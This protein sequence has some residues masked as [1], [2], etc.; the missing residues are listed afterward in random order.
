MADI[1]VM[2]INDGRIAERLFEEDATE[3][4]FQ[5]VVKIVLAKEAAV[6]EQ[7]ERTNQGMVTVKT[8]PVNYSRHEK[9]SRSYGS[10]E[11][12]KM[13]I[14]NQKCE[15]MIGAN[16][17]DAANLEEKEIVTSVDKVFVGATITLPVIVFVTDAD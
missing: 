1:F 13:K 15:I 7:S 14:K 5:R 6:K 3:T 4:T 17:Q 11:K 12:T 2:F 9:L 10:Q 8:E 16:R